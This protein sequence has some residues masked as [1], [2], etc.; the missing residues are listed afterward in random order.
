VASALWATGCGVVVIGGLKV[1]V[2]LKSQLPSKLD[3]CAVAGSSAAAKARM[4]IRLT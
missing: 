4:K 1:T 2:P 3:A